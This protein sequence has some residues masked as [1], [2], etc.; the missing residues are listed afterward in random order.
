MPAGSTSASPQPPLPRFLAAVLPVALAGFLGSVATRP[1]IPTWYEGLVKPFFTPPNWLFA[2]VWT[3]L[4][5][6]MAYAIW[7]ILSLP[8]DRPGHTGAI[9][10]FYTQLVLNAL[11]SWAF[12]AAHSP[13]AGLVVIA[14][15][16]VALMTTI[17]L[18][19]ALD[20][21]AAWLLV[22]YLAWLLYAT[23]LN[24]AVWWLN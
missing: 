12:F 1:N 13:F 11:W 21:I 15:L 5:V 6:M 23:A 2:P 10:S 9:I 19:A 4:Y 14:A 24:A 22:P 8:R 17:K 18:F 20:R 7:R 16:I 3:L